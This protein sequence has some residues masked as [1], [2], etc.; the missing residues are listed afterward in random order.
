MLSVLL[1]FFSLGW[2]E[3]IGDW[4][5][6]SMHGRGIKKMYGGDIYEGTWASGMAHGW[7]CKLF[8]DG[9]QHEGSYVKDKRQGCAR[10]AS[11][12]FLV[13]SPYR[14]IIRFVSPYFSSVC[15]RYG[16]YTWK[17]GDRYEGMW[18]NGRM[19]GRGVK[20]IANGDIHVGMWLS[21]KVSIVLS[22]PFLWI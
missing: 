22:N 3:N 20:T 9:D 6:G 7:G 15:F 19:C 16:E 11:R 8:L 17:N 10:C 5:N 12:C 1:L 13:H 4:V 21:D 14:K 2:L 18:K